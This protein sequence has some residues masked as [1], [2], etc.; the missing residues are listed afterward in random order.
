M[1]EEKGGFALF[2]ESFQI[3]LFHGGD[4]IGDLIPSE[5]RMLFSEGAEDISAL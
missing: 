5:I 3:V 4:S 1:K 2:S